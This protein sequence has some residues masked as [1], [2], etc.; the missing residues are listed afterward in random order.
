LPDLLLLDLQMPH[1]NGLEVLQ[2]I[3]EQP[4]LRGLRVVMLTAA[5]QARYVNLAYQLGANSYLV[6]PVDFEHFVRVSQV[7]KGHWLWMAE[8]PEISRPSKAEEAH[9]DDV[10]QR[11]LGGSNQSPKT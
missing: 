9:G 4:N 7:L 2:W 8:T 5:D 10:T 1:K 3:R 6:K 11:R